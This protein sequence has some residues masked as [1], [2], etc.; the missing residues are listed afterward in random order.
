MRRRS[1]L[2]CGTPA[3]T[4]TTGPPSPTSDAQG[5]LLGG[6]GVAAAVVKRNAVENALLPPALVALTRQK[7]CVPAERPE[8]ASESPTIPA[9]ST[10]V[11][12]NEE[13]V[14]TWSR[15]VSAP[16]DAFQDSVGA[17]DTS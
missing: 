12:L 16:T 6:G 15:Y 4:A 1:T 17:S 5:S 14:E 13:L 8:M 10:I 2:N 11:P 9:W 3:V 7:Y